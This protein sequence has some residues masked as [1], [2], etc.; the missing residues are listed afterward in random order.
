MYNQC[1]R[2]IAAGNQGYLNGSGDNVLGGNKVPV[3]G[4]KESCAIQEAP[5][6]D[7]SRRVVPTSRCRVPSHCFLQAWFDTTPL[8]VATGQAELCFN[9]P[10]PC[11]PRVPLQGFGHNSCHTKSLCCRQT[12]PLGGLWRVLLNKSVVTTQAE[13]GRRVTLIS[14][15]LPPLGGFM[16]VPR[17]AKRPE[18]E[19]NS[20]LVLSI[21]ITGLRARTN[22]GEGL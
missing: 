10:L 22:A 4:D 7:V 5:A 16:L 21:G 18:V 13:L 11:R 9:K 6:I 12:E 8:C 14:S 19:S 17:S 2:V 15:F 3:A 1:R 20:E